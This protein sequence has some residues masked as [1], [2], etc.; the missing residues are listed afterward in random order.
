MRVTKSGQLRNHAIDEHG[1]SGALVTHLAS[2]RGSWSVV[3]IRLEP[4]G[5]V[6][7]HTA[8]QDQLFSVVSGGGFV[9]GVGS[10]PVLLAERNTVLWASGQ[11]HETTTRSEGLVAIVV[12]GDSLAET[13]LFAPDPN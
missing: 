5:V 2:R 6:G 3:Q 8:G 12:E 7:T 11:E 9:H 10:E 1:S 13:L 4:G